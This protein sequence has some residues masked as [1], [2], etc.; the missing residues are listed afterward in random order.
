MFLQREFLF[1]SFKYLESLPIQHYFKLL[2]SWFAFCSFVLIILF[3]STTQGILIWIMLTFLRGA[4]PPHCQSNFFAATWGWEEFF[5]W[6]TFSLRVCS[7]LEAQLEVERFSYWTWLVF[8]LWL[9]TWDYDALE[10]K[11]QDLQVPWGQMWLWYFFTCL[12]FL[13]S[14]RFCSGWSLPFY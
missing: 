1:P 10:I 2:N 5:F 14:L 12:V 6:L 7:P 11:I 4:P 3:V 13:I 9:F 8:G